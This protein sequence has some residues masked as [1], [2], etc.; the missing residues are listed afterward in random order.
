MSTG[1]VRTGLFTPIGAVDLEVA[2]PSHPIGATACND[3]YQANLGIRPLSADLATTTPEEI[4][5]HF[6]FSKSDV[7]LLNSCAPCTGFSQKQ[8]RNHINDDARNTLVERTAVFAAAWMPKYVVVENVKELLRG[9][10]KHHFHSLHKQLSSLGYEVFAEVHDLKH[11]GLPQ[12]RIRSLI[13]A[14][15]GEQFHFNVPPRT[16]FNTVR[17]AIGHLPEL[18]AGNTDPNDLMHVAPNTKGTSLDRMRAIPKDGGSWIDIPD[19]LAHLR[20]PSMNVEKPGSFPDVYGRLSWDKP[21]PTVTRECS[22]PG[23]GRYSHPE[24]DRLLSVREM[25]LLQGFPSSYTFLGSLSS[26]YRQ[27]GDAVPPIVAQQI[28]EAILADC[29]GLHQNCAPQRELAFSS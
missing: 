12:S 29:Q 28:A 17:D 3:T 5:K 19:C 16:T 11:L 14:K 27:I 26:K 15:L 7:E 13:I 21:A 10:H 1:F 22:H 6:G 8:S 9:R 24:Q 18:E 2:K 25:A 23:N 4:S 20:I